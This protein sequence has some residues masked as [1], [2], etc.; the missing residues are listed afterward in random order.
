MRTPAN[1]SLV[2]S[3]AFHTHTSAPHK[4]N[5][6]TCLL[7]MPTKLQDLSIN[8]MWSPSFSLFI[9]FYKLTCCSD[10][11]KHPALSIRHGRAIGG[12]VLPQDLHAAAPRSRGNSIRVIPRPVPHQDPKV[13]LSVYLKRGRSTINDM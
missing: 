12:V 9:F 4:Y 10:P 6:F 1:T 2:L 7:P 3:V 5:L 11:R 8:S 13:I